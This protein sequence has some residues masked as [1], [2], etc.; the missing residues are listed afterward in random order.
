MFRSPSLGR[1]ARSAG[2]VAAAAF[3][4]AGPA[5]S[6][7]QDESVSADV[8]DLA[9]P[10]VDLLLETSSLDRTVRRTEGAEDVRVTLAADVLF[11]FNRARLSPRAG[12][13]IAEVTEEVRRLSPTTVTVEGF[14]D[15][16]GSQSYNLGLSRRRAQSVRSALGRA[17]DGG[18]PRVVATGRGESRPVAANTKRDGSDSPAGRARNRR[19]EIR[20]PES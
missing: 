8:L 2:L 14:T 16:K 12:K 3:A 1:G 9:L 5:P 4:A 13:R 10:V 7:A 20:I 6:V 19:V 15:T 11:A 18:G 17:L